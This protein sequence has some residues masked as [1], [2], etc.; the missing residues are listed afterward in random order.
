MTPAVPEE[1][2]AVAELLMCLPRGGLFVWQHLPQETVAFQQVLTDLRLGVFLC[3]RVQSDARVSLHTGADLSSGGEP[4]HC[5]SVD[6]SVVDDPVLLVGPE[7]N[8]DGATTE[9]WSASSTSAASYPPSSW[10]NDRVR[11]VLDTQE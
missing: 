7:T 10:M 8:G 3:C 1:G 5:Q 2:D 11:P 9:G 4:G 6:V